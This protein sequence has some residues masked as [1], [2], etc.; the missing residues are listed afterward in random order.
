MMRDDMTARAGS[1]AVRKGAEGNTAIREKL[2]RL[3]DEA[4]A[5]RVSGG[6]G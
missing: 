5:V 2:K 1:Q 6:G 3:I 4:K